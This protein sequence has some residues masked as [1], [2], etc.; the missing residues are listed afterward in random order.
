MTDFEPSDDY[1]LIERD[2][3]AEPVGAVCGAFDG[4]YVP[5]K[6]WPERIAELQE[7]QMR[8]IDFHR[9]HK[10]PIL[11]QGRTKYC[12][13]YSLVAGVMNR[14]A[15]QGINDPVPHLS[16]TAVAAVGMQYKNQGGYCAHGVKMIQDQ[17][18][19]PTVDVWPT[20]K[21]DRNYADDPA[22]KQSRK[23][24][25]LTRFVD[26]GQDLD[27]AI[28]MMIGE[29]PIPVTFSLPWW[30][31]AVLGLEVIDTRQGDS[32]SLDR[33]GV[34]FVN[35]YGEVWQ[36]DGYGEF[37]GDR[38]KSWEHVGISHIKPTME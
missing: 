21:I 11:N 15:F 17:G 34:R 6:E 14:L 31:H 1:G 37:Y 12:W 28:S 38:M 13:M 4:D 7:H 24:H 10:V 32:E 23:E 16:A 5:R 18:G 27:A 35:S 30:R 26:A 22:V 19:I 33:Y 8:P 2:Y 3:L 25:Q 29:T 20:Q 36:Q 9:F